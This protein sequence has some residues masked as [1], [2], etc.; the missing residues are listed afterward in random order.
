MTDV[1]PL[2]KTY[3]RG[4]RHVFATLVVKGAMPSSSTK[5][6]DKGKEKAKDPIIDEQENIHETEYEFQLIDL[7]EEDE[8]K[9]T[10]EIIKGKETK[11]NEIQANLERGKYV[12][13]FLEQ[14]NQQLKT[15]GAINE[16]KCIKAQR[17]PGKAKALMEETLERYGEIDDEED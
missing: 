3:K 2:P 9:I 11:I 15:K 5:Q 16:V 8:D 1:E 6:V 14:E 4:Y 17:E 10:H 13:D 7:Y 12:I